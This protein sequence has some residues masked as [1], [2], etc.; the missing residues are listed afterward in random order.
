MLQKFERFRQ[1]FDLYLKHTPF[2]LDDFDVNLYYSF[3]YLIPF[4]YWHINT[5]FFIATASRGFGFYSDTFDQVIYVLD[6]HE[7]RMMFLSVPAMRCSRSARSIGRDIY[8]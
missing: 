2:Y 4:M 1:D 8:Y 7:F 3:S 5:T 6:T